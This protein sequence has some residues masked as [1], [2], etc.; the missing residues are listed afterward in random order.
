MATKKEIDVEVKEV[1]A[2]DMANLTVDLDIEKQAKETALEEAAK[3]QKQLDDLTK[4]NARLMK[5]ISEKDL[6][7][8]KTIE[9][10]KGVPAKI[11]DF[12]DFSKGRLVIKK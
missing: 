11:T 2:E 12:Y 6:Q 9:K 3:L 7:E 8:E 5:R 1:T 4:A 10:E